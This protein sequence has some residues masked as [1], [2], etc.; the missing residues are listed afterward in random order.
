MLV[1]VDESG[2]LG[3]KFERGSTRFFTIALVIFESVEAAQACQRAIER[4]KSALDL[5][6]R[7]EFHFHD[8]THER[9]LALLSTAAQQD[10]LCHTFTLDKSSPKLTGEGFQYRGSAY[11]W[12]C[13]IV[14]DNAAADVR[15]ATVVIDGSGE[16][17]FRQEISTYLRRE[18]NAEQRRQIRK[19]KIGRSTSDPLLQLADYVAGVTN[20]WY[21][22]KPGADAYE[23][24]LRRKRRSQRKWP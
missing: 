6:P 5:P 22:G 2:D 7:F 12:V 11:K 3:F 16:R 15:E 9:R 4:L 14:L 24:Y 13:K 17:R 18:L 8:D 23:Q 10:F 19:V 1:F 21:E 20:R